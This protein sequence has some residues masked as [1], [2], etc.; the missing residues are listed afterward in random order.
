MCLVVIV[1]VVSNDAI[2]S[3]AR[4][5][6]VHIFFFFVLGVSAIRALF[7]R[8]A[9]RGSSKG[10]MTRSEFSRR[11][12]QRGRIFPNNQLQVLVCRNQRN[13]WSHLFRLCLA[14][15][16]ITVGIVGH[17]CVFLLTMRVARRTA[18]GEVSLRRSVGSRF[19]MQSVVLLDKRGMARRIANPTT[20]H[21]MRAVAL[22]GIATIGTDVTATIIPLVEDATSTGQLRLGPS[23]SSTASPR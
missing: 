4:G 17:V 14:S 6:V 10:S 13:L 8:T 20:G 1:L 16:T 21:R 11:W 2:D 15:I 12:L 5:N 19:I 7:I 22:I 3:E 23:S 18:I 9:Y